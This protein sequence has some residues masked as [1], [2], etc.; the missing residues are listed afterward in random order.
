MIKDTS[1][2]N[3]ISVASLVNN[4]EFWQFSIHL[5]KRSSLAISPEKHLKGQDCCIVMS[6]G[7]TVR[8]LAS[9]GTTALSESSQYLI[10]YPAGVIFTSWW[11][12]KERSISLDSFSL[13][14][15]H[16][17]EA[18][19]PFPWNFSTLLSFDFHFDSLW[20]LAAMVS[21]FAFWHLILFISFLSHHKISSC[22]FYFGI[23]MWQKN[24]LNKSVG[25]GER[26]K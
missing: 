3:H 2:L 13:S 10:F 15:S 5:Y 19:C 1:I 4:A 21:V 11:R 17:L 18:L 20:L 8:F 23:L 16:L 12:M 25:S 6:L 22:I 14:L 7:S 24:E 9:S 26:L